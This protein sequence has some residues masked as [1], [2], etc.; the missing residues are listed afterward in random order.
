MLEIRVNDIQK[1]VDTLEEAVEFVVREVQRWFNSD[2]QTPLQITLTKPED[3]AGPAL[4]I[5]VGDKLPT[6]EALG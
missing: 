3:R 5:N 2:D 6:K 1:V 4:Q